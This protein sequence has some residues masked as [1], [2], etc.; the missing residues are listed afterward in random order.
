MKV[1]KLGVPAVLVLF[2]SLLPP[3][4][5]VS[6]APEPTTATSSV[7]GSGADPS[8]GT[9]TSSPGDPLPNNPISQ[10]GNDPQAEAY[11]KEFDIEYGE[12]LKRPHAREAF[13]ATF[14]RSSRRSTTSN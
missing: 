4:P 9:N 12:A 13:Y 14:A 2:G 10:T 7:D 11:A 1:S 8:F 5:A 3:A 6:A